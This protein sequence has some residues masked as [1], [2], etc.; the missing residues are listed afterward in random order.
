MLL[1]TAHKRKVIEKGHTN[2]SHCL[3]SVENAFH[4]LAFN[5]YTIHQEVPRDSILEKSNYCAKSIRSCRSVLLLASSTRPFFLEQD[6]FV[7]EVR[8]LMEGAWSLPG[9]QEGCTRVPDRRF[10]L[11]EARP[12]RVL[13]SMQ[14]GSLLEVCILH[15]GLWPCRQGRHLLRGGK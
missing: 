13:P 7:R 9:Q 1:L 10:A 6:N 3:S 2:E 14:H 8:Q 11:A 5:D 12:A 15:P 4:T